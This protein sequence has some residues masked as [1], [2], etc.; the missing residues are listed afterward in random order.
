VPRRWVPTIAP[1]DAG[2]PVHGP[3]L[4]SQAPGISAALADV[5]AHADPVGL[6][7]QLDL[8]AD[9]VHAEAAA[10]QM[11]DQPREPLDAGGAKAEQGSE[12]VL[13][14]ELND[15]ADRV[16]TKQSSVRTHE[17]SATGEFRFSLQASYW[18]GELPEDRRVRVTISWLQ[19]G[20]PE[21]EHVLVLALS[22]EPPH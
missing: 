3:L 2:V 1:D 18:I 11:L 4:L 19:A 5:R 10:R 13:H 7:L 8:D 20:L 14:V 9:G 17:D 6:M 15:L 12:P 22:T 21:M 16:P